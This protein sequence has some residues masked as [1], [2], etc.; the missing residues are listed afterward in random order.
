MKEE[1]I[2]KYE[3]KGSPSFAHVAITLEKPGDEI[4]AEGGAM[5]YMDGH[6]QMTTKS[7]GG[8]MKG[9]K[10]KLSGESM[11]QNLFSIPEGSDPGTVIFSHGVPGDIVH[12]HLKQGEQWILSGDG[13]IC[14]TIGIGVST[15]ASGKQWIGGEEIFQ[16]TVTAQEIEENVLFGGYGMVERLEIAPEKEFVVDTSIMMACY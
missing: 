16:T 3:I 15:T 12:L 9:L 10:R 13:Y 4:V 7:S 5:I 6:I 14:S 2:L 11:F 8:I 1:S